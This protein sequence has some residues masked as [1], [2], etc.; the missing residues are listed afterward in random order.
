MT[1]LG[2]LVL[3][4]GILQSWDSAGDIRESPDVPGR[5]PPTPPGPGAG[6][7]SHAEVSPVF[8]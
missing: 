6:C 8:G 2:A 4:G 7:C 3:L 5:G 1:S